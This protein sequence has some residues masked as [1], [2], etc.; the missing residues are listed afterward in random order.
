VKNQK[1]EE[2]GRMTYF[3]VMGKKEKAGRERE[4]GGGEF[5]V[6]A[7]GEFERG[8]TPRV[9]KNPVGGGGGGVDENACGVTV[10]AMQHLT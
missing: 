1:K 10:V 4:R 8:R 6:V 2:G 3:D 5:G 9:R 7:D